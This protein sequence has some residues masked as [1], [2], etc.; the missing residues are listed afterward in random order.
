MEIG[1]MDLSRC[2]INMSPADA[3]KSDR[4]CDYVP[5]D[6]VSLTVK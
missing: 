5:D 6:K 2:D 3:K 1:G 4:G